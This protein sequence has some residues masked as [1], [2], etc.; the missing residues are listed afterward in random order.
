MVLFAWLTGQYL[1]RKV[2]EGVEKAAY[3]THESV[4]SAQA[5]NSKIYTYGA[6][7]GL[8][9]LA[10][11]GTYAARRAHENLGWAGDLL[12]K[13]ISGKNWYN[14][15]ANPYQTGVLLATELGSWYARRRV[16]AELRDESVVT[17][18]RLER[19]EEDQ[20]TDLAELQARFTRG[21]V[22]RN[23]YRQGRG[24]ISNRYRKE[25]YE[26]IQESDEMPTWYSLYS[27]LP[28]AVR[29]SVTGSLIFK[30]WDHL[31]AALYSF[32]PNAGISDLY[33]TLPAAILGTLTTVPLA[34]ISGRD[35]FRSG[36]RVAN[37]FRGRRRPARE[38]P[39]EGEAERP[40]EVIPPR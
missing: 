1:R 14:I 25:R 26:T 6:N 3:Q 5:D 39:P 12:L 17:Q 23:D 7:I 8:S 37:L 31:N 27:I 22:N 30:E 15:V 33:T 28:A 36:R 29:T 10:G 2:Q 40:D 11:L 24:A 35:A 20:E 34:C 32:S 38:G 16:Q 18:R 4:D 9:A 13:P 21:E 19:L